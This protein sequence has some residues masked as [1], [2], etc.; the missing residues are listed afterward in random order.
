MNKYINADAL[1]DQLKKSGV[2]DEVIEMIQKAPDEDV[3]PTVV[4]HW[5][6]MRS[7]E[8]IA[9]SCC[10]IWFDIPASTDDMENYNYCPNCGAEMEED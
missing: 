8:C 5:K 10:D 3:R 7:T 2:S 1:I 4:A 9:C 6:F